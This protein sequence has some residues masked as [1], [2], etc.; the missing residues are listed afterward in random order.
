MFASVSMAAAEAQLIF[1]EMGTWANSALAN[2]P[3]KHYRG[4]VLCI[5]VESPFAYIYPTYDWG[6]LRASIP[7]IVTHVDQL[8]TFLGV[9]KPHKPLVWY[10]INGIYSFLGLP[11]I[12]E[13]LLSGVLMPM[14]PGG[15]E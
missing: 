4:Y 2:S 1:L 15:I 12:C 8:P 9:H 3:F 11:K 13:F 5:P 7:F 6:K 14:P 10:W